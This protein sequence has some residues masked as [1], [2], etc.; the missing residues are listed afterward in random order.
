MKFFLLFIC[1]LILCADSNAQQADLVLTNGNI[2]T[3]RVK[4]DRAQAI[5]IKG[6][7]IIAVGTNVDIA[8]LSGANTQVIDLKGKTVLPGF[9]DVHQHPA[10]LYTFEKP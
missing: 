7:E 10:P 6:D 1:F 9:N 2:V 4:G 3:L 5:A 8:K